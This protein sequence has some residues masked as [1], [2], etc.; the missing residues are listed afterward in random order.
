VKKATAS[1]TMLSMNT[2]SFFSRAMAPVVSDVESK[3]GI[4]QQ[5]R[6]ADTPDHNP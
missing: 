4:F 5:E 6:N 2:N 1:F 3:Q